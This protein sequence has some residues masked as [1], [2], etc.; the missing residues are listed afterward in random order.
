MLL[1]C[2]AAG[3]MMPLSLNSTGSW[4]GVGLC[5]V[6]LKRQGMIYGFQEGKQ[7]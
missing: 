4:V 3:M 2:F 7:E 6:F 5:G 1:C